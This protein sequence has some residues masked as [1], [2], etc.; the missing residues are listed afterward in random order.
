MDNVRH[1][2]GNGG[3]VHVLKR[4][5]SEAQRDHL[6]MVAAGVAFYAFFA[7]FPAIAAVVSVYGL[8]ADPQTVQQ[9]LDALGGVLPDGVRD[10][11]GAQMERVASTSGGA[12]GFGFALSLL[13]ALWSANRGTRSMI[14][15]LNIA[16][17]EQEK[18]GK[19]KLAALSLLLT[20]GGVLA[21][22]VAVF[23]VVAVPALVGLF[24]LGGF[25]RI[26]VNVLRWPLLLGVM[27]LGLAVLYRFAPSRE[28]PAWKWVTPGSLLATA[29]WLAAS[30]AF[31]LYVANFG[32]YDKT[33][34]SLA[35]VAI[36]LMWL[37]VGL[38][39]V[40]LGAEFNATA[41]RLARQS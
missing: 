16:Y 3:F 28:G 20:L 5:R 39:V 37:Y 31:S 11:L 38:Y 17:D 8:V 24:D 19:A 2:L 23:V 9:Q 34:G 33:F 27:L 35:A 18:R 26:A 29:L 10:I 25:S 32:S 22:V 4:T 41:E 30:L 21:V 6:S 13:I 40:L 12:L 15:A 36:L 14:E 1:T 7:L